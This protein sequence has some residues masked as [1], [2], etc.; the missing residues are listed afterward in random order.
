MKATKEKSKKAW[1]IMRVAIVLMVFVMLFGATTTSTAHAYIAKGNSSTNVMIVQTK[2]KYWGYYTGAI[3][4]VFG[5][6]TKAAVK[7]FQSRKGLTADGVVGS[8][9]EKALGVSLS[10][11]SYP[12]TIT[13][14]ETK[15]NV[16]AVQNPL[17][18]WG[19]YTGAVDGV[20][21]AKT[22]AAVISF[23]VNNGLT[24]DGIVGPSVEKALGINLS[25]AK[26]AS[27]GVSS[28]SNNDMYLLAKAIYAE[29]RGEPYTGQ[30]A[31]GAVILNRVKSPKF[32]NTISGVIYQP[33]A[34]TAVDDGQINL[35]PNQTAINAAKDAMNGWDPTNGC[36]YYYNPATATSKWIWSL[37][38]T[39][40]IG[41]HS[42]AKG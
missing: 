15:E 20:Y 41:K 7:N 23:Q 38:V 29:A 22:R 19:Y 42:F 1:R 17:K 31:V 32:P 21:G 25:G 35:T 4:G 40:K 30:V 33:G 11:S 3:D 36:L 26:S 13:K 37:E 39:L 18:K 12:T 10:A 8:K 24:V 2:L 14:G 6:K 5:A 9:T 16:K 27:A 34:F 28:Y